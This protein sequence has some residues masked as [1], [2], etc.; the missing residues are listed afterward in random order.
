MAMVLRIVIFPVGEPANKDLDVLA[1]DLAAAGFE[2]AVHDGKELP[3]EAYDSARD[4]F[5]ADALLDMARDGARKRPGEYLLAVTDADLYAHGLNF[6]FGIADPSGRAAAIS[7]NRLGFGADAHT[8]RQRA[9]KEA[10]HEIGHT[11]GLGHCPDPRC[12]MWFSNRLEETDSKR[13]TFCTGCRRQIGE[14]A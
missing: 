13:A 14:R 9:L 4:Q 11:L 3:S 8:F 1:L 7:L 2:A 10:V 12:V 5:H 6:V